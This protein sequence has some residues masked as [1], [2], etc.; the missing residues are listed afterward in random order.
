[1]KRAPFITLEG[2]EGCG[3]S[4]H[5]SLL[6][7]RIRELGLPA[8]LTHEPGATE[9]GGALRRLLADP[10]GPDPCPQAEL[11]LYLA[12]RAQHLEQVIRPALAAGEAV[13][14]DRFA[15]STQVYQGLARGLGADRVRELNRWLC[16]DTWPDLTIVLDLDPALGL[17]R[18]RHRQGKQGLDRLEQAGGEFHRLV[19][20]GFLELARQEP[21]RVRLI[22]AA[23][24]RPE[25]ARRIWEVARPLLESWRKTREA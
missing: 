16:G 6:A 1:M 25:V 21:E 19:R 2:G 15:D 17:A 9:L 24:S 22:E 13:V 8:L 20:E 10:A 12:D 7:Q 5:A 11:L 3:K 18:A 4:T 23:G 14:C